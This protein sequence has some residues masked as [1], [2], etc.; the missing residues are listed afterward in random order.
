MPVFTARPSPACMRTTIHS[1]P[2]LLSI[3][4]C[5][6]F[7]AK[8]VN[9]VSWAELSLLLVSFMPFPVISQQSYMVDVR[10]RHRPMDICHFDKIETRAYLDP[11]SRLHP[12]KP[13]QATPLTSY[14]TQLPFL[15][16]AYQGQSCRLATCENMGGGRGR[17]GDGMFGAWHSVSL[18]YQLQEWTV[19]WKAAILCLSLA[20]ISHRNLFTWSNLA[21][22]IYGSSIFNTKKRVSKRST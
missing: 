13:W 6:V 16:R 1:F 22:L 3:L 20:S 5:R 15:L 8:I 14:F 18:Q 21:S 10:K 12:I 17:G 4:G 11:R 2:E 9:R 7:Q 19:R